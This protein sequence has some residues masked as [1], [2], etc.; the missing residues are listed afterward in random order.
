MGSRKGDF[1]WAAL[2]LEV[3]FLLGERESICWG[4]DCSNIFGGGKGG[5]GSGE[6]N[7]GDGGGGCGC[8]WEEGPA[9]GWD[10]SWHIFW[11]PLPHCP[12]FSSSW[13]WFPFVFLLFAGLMIYFSFL[14]FLLFVML[15][16]LMLLVSL[17]LLVSFVL[18]VSLV[19]LMSLVLVLLVTLVVVRALVC[20]WGG[21]CFP[22][23]RGSLPP[24]GHLGPALLVVCF[25]LDLTG[26]EPPP[27]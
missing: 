9:L 5:G 6:G 21:T 20:F 14:S 24:P 13:Y 8:V 1:V 10:F 7:G 12:F 27:N 26:P 22:L 17:E 19:L 15:G 2:S 18:L 11:R 23:F 4:G 3:L 16:M 25:G